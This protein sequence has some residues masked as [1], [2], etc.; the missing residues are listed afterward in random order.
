MNNA[1]VSDIE[2][3]QLK[4]FSSVLDAHLAHPCPSESLRVHERDKIQNH[5][6]R[7]ELPVELYGDDSWFSSRSA[8]QRK[9]LESMFRLLFKRMLSANE[10]V[11]L[12]PSS[13][14]FLNANCCLSKGVKNKLREHEFYDTK[15]CCRRALTESIGR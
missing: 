12:L 2:Q 5:D 4:S 10:L 6:F 13:W 1:N 14:L 9:F 15:V 7:L 8:S 11:T 3:D